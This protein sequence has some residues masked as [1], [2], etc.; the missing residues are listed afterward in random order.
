MGATG[1]E[2]QTA[3]DNIFRTNGSQLT[4]ER[5]TVKIDLFYSRDDKDPVDWLKNFERAATV[6]RWNELT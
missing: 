4:G 1:A 3:L 2:I 6:N 5:T